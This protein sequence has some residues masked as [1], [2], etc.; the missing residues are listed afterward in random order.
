MTDLARK[1]RRLGM[2]KGARELVGPP[3]RPAA[4]RY[5]EALP[6][7]QQVETPMGVCF[8]IEERYPPTYFHGQSRLAGLLG[9]DPTAAAR[10]AAD[11]Q[12][13]RF[14]L[15]QALFI[16][17]ETTGLG[18]GAGVLAFLIGAG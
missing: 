5:A 11:P 6:P 9:H 17:T 12:P 18:Q 10:M 16:D 1:L 2:V 14:D 3:P 8:F 7:G 13:E 4:P 15:S